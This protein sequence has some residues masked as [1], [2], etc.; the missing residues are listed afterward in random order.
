MGVLS[1]VGKH[2]GTGWIQEKLESVTLPDISGKLRIGIIGN[3]DYT[4]SG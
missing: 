4:L 1:V 3:I 2:V